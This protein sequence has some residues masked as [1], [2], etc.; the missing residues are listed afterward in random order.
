MKTKVKPSELQINSDF[1]TFLPREKKE[2][3]KPSSPLNVGRCLFIPA[4]EDPWLESPNQ[5][6]SPGQ[7]LLTNGPPRGELRLYHDGL[8]RDHVTYLK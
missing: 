6:R 1:S 2:Y 4:Q 8:G 7:H 5:A 3:E